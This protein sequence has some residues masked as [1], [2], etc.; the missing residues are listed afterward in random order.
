M[1]NLE[2]LRFIAKVAR[3]YYSTGMTQSAIA[4][5]LDISQATVSRLLKR[6]VAEKI[7][8]ITVSM[9][10]GVYADLE[11]QLEALYGLKRAIVV[12]CPDGCDD[13]LLLD[14]LGAAAAYYI[15]TT[16]TQD[17]IIGIS[18]W[19]ATLLAMV[20]AMPKLNRQL[21]VQIVQILGGVGSPS[22]EVYASRLTD[23]LAR[24][25]NARTVFLPAP[26]VVASEEARMSLLSD[27]FVQE[28]M[29]FFDQVTM[30]LVGIGDI[31]P[32]KLLAS[33]GNVFAD[34]ELET[35]KQV[36]AVGD[37]CLR[38]FD[39]DGNPVI[40]PL[41]R[42]VIG[43]SLD[44]LQ[45]VRRCVGIAGGERKYAAIRGALEGRWLNVLITDH[46]TAARLVAE[47]T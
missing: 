20:D 14:A 18:S 26:G 10:T 36:G 42:R 23:R 3:L 22:A 13:T 1:L 40:V 47:R 9:P 21:N 5:Q 24:A 2:E 17:E 29:R 27:Q 19:S 41:D 25:V 38:F 8:R 11:D 46:L 7:V 37:I 12:D 28:A 34:E 33:S 15:E 45:K 30:A 32:S 35:L 6:A 31:Q 39:A 4:R 44:Q 43:I 16:I